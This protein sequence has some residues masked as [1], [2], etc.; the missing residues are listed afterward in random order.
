[1]AVTPRRVE[2]LSEVTILTEVLHDSDLPVNGWWFQEGEPDININEGWIHECEVTERD[3]SCPE[4]TATS[5]LLAETA[6]YR[7]QWVGAQLMECPCGAKLAFLWH[8]TEDY[9]SESE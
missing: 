7:S 1:M 3:N 5:L 6:A 2:Q 4:V 9:G 8:Q